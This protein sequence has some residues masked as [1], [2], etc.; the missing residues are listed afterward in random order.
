MEGCLGVEL[1]TESPE[2]SFLMVLWM[3]VGPSTGSQGCTFKGDCGI[4]VVLLT[5]RSPLAALA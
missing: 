1:S 2:V 3:G 5:D 4:I